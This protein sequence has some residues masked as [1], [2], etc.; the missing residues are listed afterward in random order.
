MVKCYPKYGLLSFAGMTFL[1][2]FVFSSVFESTFSVLFCSLFLIFFSSLLYSSLLLISFLLSFSL[3]LFSF[4]SLLSHFSLYRGMCGTQEMNKK[5]KA[6]KGKLQEDYD[7]DLANQPIIQRHML[8][9]EIRRQ[10][11]KGRHNKK[12]EEEE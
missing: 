11:I 9:R 5:L 8:D 7:S 12:D 2:L 4:C 1:S 3:F 10:K 6:K